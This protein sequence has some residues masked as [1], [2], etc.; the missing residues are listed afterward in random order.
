MR[1]IEYSSQSGTP[2]ELAERSFVRILSSLKKA[3][4][5]F[6][7]L[8]AK[9]SS[10]LRSASIVKIESENSSVIFR[11]PGDGSWSPRRIMGDGITQGE[12]HQLP[13]SDPRGASDP[14]SITG[15][16]GRFQGTP[17]TDGGFPT[18]RKVFFSSPIPKG[19]AEEMNQSTFVV[20]TVLGLTLAGYFGLAAWR[21]SGGDRAE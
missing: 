14:G 15:R 4:A 11:L 19:G 12:P 7:F 8:A 3:S 10:G 20:L 1:R 6:C 16:C 2:P 21:V 5:S 9:A 18:Q 17:V 13:I